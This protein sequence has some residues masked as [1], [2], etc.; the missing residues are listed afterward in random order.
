MLPT[1]YG[2]PVRA[3]YRYRRWLGSIPSQHG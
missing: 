1:S 3:Q 2:R